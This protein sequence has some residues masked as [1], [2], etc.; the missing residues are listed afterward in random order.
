MTV[1]GNDI[2]IDSSEG[3]QFDAYLAAPGTKDKVPAI[4]LASAIHGVDT[5]VRGIADEFAAQGFLAIAPD[6]F[7]R[8]TPGPL[9]R[10]D[11][12]ASARAQPRLERIKAG[13]RDLA[14]TRAFV[15]KHALSNGKA[16]VM[17]FCYGGPYA[18]LGPKRLGFDAGISCHGSQMMDYVAE[19]EGVRLPVCVIWGDND[20][21][22]P[23]PVIGAYR[24][25][26][27]E[28]K[29]LEVEIL[30]GPAHGYMMKGGKAYDARAYAFSMQRA[31]EILR[32]LHV[33][34]TPGAPPT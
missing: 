12:N 4:V 17:G 9:K 2:R 6:L 31:L 29:S 11:P 16:A 1:T 26:A 19:L 24:D 25:R 14:D 8:T 30:A 5:D 20:T 10:D 21:A 34:V 13:E 18:V 33:G 15:R 23:G 7:W 32:R 3:G 22:A 28:M 27:R